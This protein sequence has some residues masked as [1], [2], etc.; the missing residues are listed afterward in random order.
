M[1]PTLE[2]LHHA[3]AAAKTMPKCRESAII[4]TKIEEAQMWFGQYLITHGNPPPATPA[5][6]G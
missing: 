3:L 5:Q 1:H 6:G 4:I 2:N